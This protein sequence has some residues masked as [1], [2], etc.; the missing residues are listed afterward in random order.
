MH[1]T[2]QLLY[3]GR[4]LDLYRETH[5]LPDGHTADFEI[6]HQPGGCA[7]LPLHADSR[8][9]LLRQYRP[10]AGRL[11]IE[12]PAGRLEANE[13]AFDCVQR[14]LAE[15]AGLTAGRIE[16]LGSHFAA[17]GYSRERVGLFLARDLS[18]CPAAPEEDEWI[19]PFTLPL[20]EAVKWVQRG[21]IDDAKTQLALLL[22][23]VREGVCA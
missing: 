9:T 8:V 19:E 3:R 17:V 1:Q 20:V 14:E 4:I 22:C 12:I 16:P 15:E 6:I 2:E 21:E 10:A 18:A 11:V 7:V 23:A 5:R 13:A